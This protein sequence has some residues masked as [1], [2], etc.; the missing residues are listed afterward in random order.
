MTAKQAQGRQTVLGDRIVG[1]RVDPKIMGTGPI[2]PPAALKSRLE[3]GDLDLIEANEAF[4]AQACAVNKDLGWI[5]PRSTST[6]RDRDRHPVG[7]PAPACCD[8]AA[9]DAEARR[10]E[11]LA[12]LCIAAAWA[13][14]VHCTRLIM[15]A[16]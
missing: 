1:S 3:C 9:R 15:R 8:A 13:S 4:A 6:R 5:P 11:G 12:T 16:T 7:P 2:P 14:H 10:Q